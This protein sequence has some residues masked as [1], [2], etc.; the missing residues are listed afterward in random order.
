MRSGWIRSQLRWVRRVWL[1]VW[2]A[3]WWEKLPWVC[4]CRMAMV[5]GRSVAVLLNWWSG[6]MWVLVVLWVGVVESRPWSRV[7]SRG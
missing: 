5:W 2:G 6:G 7:V 1:V 3:T 4:E